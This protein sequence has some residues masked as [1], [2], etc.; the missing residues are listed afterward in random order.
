MRRTPPPSFGEDPDTE[1]AL[2]VHRG[3]VPPPRAAD[4][5]HPQGASGVAMPREWTTLPTL[6][7]TSVE[8]WTLTTCCALA[9]A[10]VGPP[11]VDSAEILRALVR[12]MG[13]SEEL[14]YRVA[15]SWPGR[16]AARHNV[17]G[18]RMAQVRR[19]SNSRSRDR[20]LPGTRPWWCCRAAG[21]TELL[22]GVEPDLRVRPAG[23][24]PAPP[25]PV[26]HWRWRDVRDHPPRWSPFV[27]R[28]R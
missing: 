6:A 27:R 20:A 12:V 17:S 15:T 14:R 26:G 4:A 5:E 21:A 16:A 2:A 11:S 28:R 22:L 9:S 23:G 1:K 3:L 24:R 8:N 18:Q 13:A 25:R 7:V 19:R 10:L